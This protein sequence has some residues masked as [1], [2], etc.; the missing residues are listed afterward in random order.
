MPAEPRPQSLM[1]Y[2]TRITC[3]LVTLDGLESTTS[4]LK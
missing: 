3:L 2:T 4:A 1:T